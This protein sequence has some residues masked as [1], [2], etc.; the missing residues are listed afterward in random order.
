MA[1][2]FQCP[3]CGGDVD[4]PEVQAGQLKNCPQCN[5]TLRVPNVAKPVAAEPPEP[6]P[7]RAAPEK[8]P[9]PK[10]EVDPKRAA[11]IAAVELATIGVVAK[12]GHRVVKTFPMVTARR[13]E[14][15]K[16]FREL[17]LAARETVGDRSEAAEKLFAQVESEVLRALQENALELGA[18]AVVGVSIQQVDV[19]GKSEVFYVAAQG[20]PVL[21]AKV[22]ASN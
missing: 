12:P 5:E 21:L 16:F 15:A 9:A 8:P 2:S 4:A 6:A 13:V 1:I 20:T 3:T 11:Q 18:N 22:E 17:L 10:K 7:K 19:S 14:G